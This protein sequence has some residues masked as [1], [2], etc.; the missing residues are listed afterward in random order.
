[1]HV[2]LVDLP[3]YTPPYDHELGS[4]LARRGHEVDLLTSPFPFGE[5]PEPVGY[6]RQEIF[7]PLSGRLRRLAPRSRVRFAVKAA[8]YLP[9]VLRLRR[10]LASLAPDVVHVQWL[11]LP[12]RDLAW[13]GEV[14][15]ER[16]T[17]FTAHDVL[18]R[19][20]ERSAALWRDVCNAVARVVVHSRRAV[21]ELAAAGVARERVVRIPHA[22]FTGPSAAARASPNGR[23]LLF[24][25]LVRD[26]KGLDVLVRALPD[27]PGARLVVAGD[28]LDP[29]EP[30]RRLAAELG[31]AER[32]EW[33]LGFV[34]EAEVAA[35]MGRAS[36]VVLPYR[37]ADSSGVL[38]TALGHGRPA[39]VSDVG[40]LGETVADFAAGRVVPPGDPA[41]LAEACRS[42][43]DDPG[44]LAA[45]SRGAERA[46]ASLTW[47][48]AAEAHERL[49][50]ELLSG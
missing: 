5:P 45:A 39:V 27:V 32:V 25:G 24:F 14:A 26:Y 16:P 20:G 6:R 33:R 35:L 34:P 46:A 47:D 42:L 11:A 22:S 1:M 36:A 37:R 49:Y 18:G 9:C 13:L 31:V 48:A 38:A 41:A 43:L 10:R 4:A 7:F 40:G 3:S 44:A 15:A 28:A 29:V 23:T 12:R 21:D 30:V 2:S 19:R 17:V 8:E 50:E